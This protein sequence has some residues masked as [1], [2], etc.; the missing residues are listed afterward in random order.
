M[1]TYVSGVSL[2]NPTAYLA[3]NTDVA[4]A[5]GSLSGQALNDFAF[6]HFLNFGA[7]EGRDPLGEVTTSSVPTILTAGKITGDIGGNGV[8]G[9]G[10]FDAAFYLTINTD[11]NSAAIA[12][13][14]ALA[15]SGK[16]VPSNFF[17][18]FALTHFVQFG[19]VEGRSPSA[20]FD[21]GAYKSAQTDVNAAIVL[22]QTTAIQHYLQFGEA[23]GRAAPAVAGAV[24]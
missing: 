12:A 17:A 11:V 10:L 18:T 9:G 8:A 5:A 13:A 23:E 2:F 7:A 6:N 15:A 16:V 4:K 3:L 24:Q 14:N 21:Q 1:A 22:H 19:A 20:A